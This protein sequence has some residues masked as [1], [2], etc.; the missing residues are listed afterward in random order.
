M[1]KFYS[2]TNKITE[3]FYL[4]FKNSAPFSLL[5][6][7]N[8]TEN[9]MRNPQK[10]QL[11]T[12]CNLSSLMVLLGKCIPQK[13]NFST[14]FSI[15]SL[16]LQSQICLFNWVPAAQVSTL[17]NLT[18]WNKFVSSN[19]TPTLPTFL[20][21]LALHESNTSKHTFCLDFMTRKAKTPQRAS[22]VGKQA[23]F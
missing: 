14:F 19:V 12:I 6:T 20:F 22:M 1:S 5:L 4:I 9:K 2:K 10:Q 3:G 18:L 15:K 13:Q 21:S 11:G 16:N 23:K 7:T 17:Q 8:N